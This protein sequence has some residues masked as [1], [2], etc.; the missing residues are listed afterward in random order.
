GEDAVI[1]TTVLP[2]DTNDVVV[3]ASDDESIATVYKGKIRAKGIGKTTI[4]AISQS[5][6]VS[7]DITVNVSA[8]DNST[9]ANIDIEKDNY[10][11][12]VGEYAYIDVNILGENENDFLTFKSSDE[13]IVSVSSIGK[14]L[15]VSKGFATVTVTASSGI[16]KVI[17][18]T[19]GDVKVKDYIDLALNVLYNDSQVKYFGNEVGESVRITGEGQ[20]TLSFD[21]DKDLSSAGQKANVTALKNL[22]AI[23]IKDL[24]VT[25][26]EDMKS[27]LTTCKIK[28]DKVLV[29]GNEMTITKT[30]EKE[31]INASGIF[32]TGDPI[33][34]YDGCAIDGVSVSSNTCNFK[35]YPKAKK[36]EVTFT[37]S[38]LKF[39]EPKAD[40]TVFAESI[41]TSKKDV[42]I[43]EVGA[44]QE[45]SVSVLPKNV[46][47]K[48]SFVSSDI[49]IVDVLNNSVMVDPET[50]IATVKI[51]AIKEGNTTVLAYIDNLTPVIF[52]V[53]T[54]KV[55]SKIDGDADGDGVLSVDDASLILQYVLKKENVD[56]SCY[57][58][59]KNKFI[60]SRDS[61]MVL[62]KALETK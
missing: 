19:V 44:E 56:S 1:N 58:V 29:D 12:A 2:T 5:G 33:N 36:I 57:D 31:A 62:V 3:W 41:T 51:K 4:K 15:A 9:I 55:I 16:T 17:K 11:F 22:T 46:N 42:V 26:A 48:V 59:D 6:S 8:N 38:D 39:I 28:Y 52:N 10:D 53:T 18:V 25:N 14:I 37:L 21:I 30:D 32:D 43:S 61:A 45:I 49:S 35:D 50:G 24:A 27:P 34:G 23:Y 40:D 60:D 13:N 7:K 20:Y 47:S 54:G